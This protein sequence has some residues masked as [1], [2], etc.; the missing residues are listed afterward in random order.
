MYGVIDK[1][2]REQFF[3]TLKECDIWLF[4]M[5]KQYGIAAYEMFSIIHS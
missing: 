2:G 5:R 3:G 1:H 4:A